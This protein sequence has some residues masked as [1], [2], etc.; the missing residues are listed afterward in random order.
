[1]RRENSCSWQYTVEGLWTSRL[2]GRWEVSSP[3]ERLRSY[4]GGPRPQYYV[5][6]SLSSWDGVRLSPLVTSASIWPIVPDPDDGW[7]C[8]V[9][10]DRWNDWQGK[11]KYSE[12]IFPST[13]SST[14]NPTWSDPGSNPGRRVITR[15][16]VLLSLQP[17][18]TCQALV[19]LTLTKNSSHANVQPRLQPWT[20]CT[21]HVKPT[22]V[23]A[24]EQLE[25]NASKRCRLKTF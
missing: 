10:S 1:V 22:L 23:H 9:W 19:P 18:C 11:P 17:H 15:P 5:A 8:C 25:H 20:K 6:F 13:V 21:D 16:S 12:K 4:H 2:H 24:D 14:T 3:A 7:W